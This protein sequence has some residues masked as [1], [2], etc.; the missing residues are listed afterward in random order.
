[1]DPP[2]SVVCAVVTVHLH[3]IEA[4]APRL[5]PVR[6]DLRVCDYGLARGVD[7]KTPQPLTECVAAECAGGANR[8]AMPHPPH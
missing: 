3:Q 2:D 4:S 6:S 8:L 5:P 7:D 1:V